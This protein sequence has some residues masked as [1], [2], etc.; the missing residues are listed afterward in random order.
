M[1]IV[2]RAEWGAAAPKSKSSTTWASR[3][4]FVVHYS[5]GPTTQTPRSIQAFHQGPARNWSD[6]GYNFL[7][8]SRGRIYEGRGWLVVGAHATGHNTSGI[9][10]CFIGRDG[11]ATDAAK[12][13]IRDLYDAACAK[14]GRTL[15][16]RGHGQLSGNSTNC[17]GKELLTW[18]KA[19]APRPK[20]DD[21]KEHP[22]AASVW[23]EVIP[24]GPDWPH[25]WKAGT[26]QR[27]TAANVAEM[28]GTL[29]DLETKH[30][31]L[32]ATLAEVLALL[33]AAPPTTP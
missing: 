8:D 16:L 33:K 7:V 1:K 15:T 26:L 32:A 19:G 5:E 17:P 27:Y 13:A 23:D 12:A 6:I 11:E 30:D 10:V 21:D 2:S 20:T 14:A 3:T 25:A 29:A 4:E 9:G 18:V 22:V 28:A 31:A 24:E